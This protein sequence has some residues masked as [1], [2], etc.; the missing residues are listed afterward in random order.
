MSKTATPV[1]SGPKR[2]T[3]SKPYE[4]RGTRYDHF[5][6]RE[7]K[8]RDLRQFIRNA[9][10]DPILAIEQALSDLIQVDLPVLGEMH[11]HDFYEMKTWFEAFLSPRTTTFD[12]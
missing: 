8:V 4:F 2:F 3:L 7:P 1:E 11:V 6:A 9:D 5:I 12:A 10:A